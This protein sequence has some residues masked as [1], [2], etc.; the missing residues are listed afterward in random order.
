MHAAYVVRH[1]ISIRGVELD[2]PTAEADHAADTDPLGEVVGDVATRMRTDG[3]RR[4]FTQGR[5]M[6]PNRNRTL[7]ELA[8]DCDTGQSAADRFADALRMIAGTD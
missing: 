7:E 5:G 8:A 2:R 1:G 3:R 6:M 4:P